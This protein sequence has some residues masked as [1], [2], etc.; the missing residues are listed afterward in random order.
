MIRAIL[1]GGGRM[2][3]SIHGV[4]T[5][6][7]V[8]V[9]AVVSL[10]RPGWLQDAVYADAL[11]TLDVDADVMIDFSLPAGTVAAA[12]WCA[13]NGMP[14]VSGVTGLDEAAFAALDRAAGQVPVLWAPNMS[15]GVNLLESLCRTVAAALDDQVPVSIHDV[16][17]R[18][19]K[20][21]PSGTAL[22]LGRAIEASRGEDA[23]PVRYTDD[24]EGEV[25]GRHVIRFDMDGEV[26]ELTHDALDRGIFASGAADAACWLCRQAPGRYRAADWLAG[27]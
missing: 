7:G 8:E 17:H 18:H 21:A 5:S 26:L 19:K 3:E 22:A 10:Q 1:H 2:A 27:R 11:D 16:H 9:V 23:P 13:G 12:D 24:R 25:V 6:R 4:A 15:V 14:F 20:D